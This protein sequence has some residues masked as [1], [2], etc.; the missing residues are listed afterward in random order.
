[1]SSLWIGIDVGGRKISHNADPGR[2]DVPEQAVPA[3]RGPTARVLSS[4]RKWRPVLNKS[5]NTYVIETVIQQGCQRSLLKKSRTSA[6]LA[7]GASSIGKWPT[8]E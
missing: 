3:N 6:T 7:A 4:V 5:A 1:M 8:P 2:K